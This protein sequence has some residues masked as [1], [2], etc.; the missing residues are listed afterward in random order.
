M[1]IVPNEL[2]YLQNFH[3]LFRRLRAETTLTTLANQSKLDQGYLKRVESG[4]TLIDVENARY[5][6]HRAFKLHERDID[7]LILGVQLFDLGLRDNAIRP[8]VVDAILK[9]LPAKT[10]RQLG[11]LYQSYTSA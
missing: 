3:R 7:R 5:L 1:S 11:Q 9:T 10:R 6:L 2:Y 8:M 4:R